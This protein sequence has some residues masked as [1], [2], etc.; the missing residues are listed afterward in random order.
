M[1]FFYKLKHCINNVDQ[2]RLSSYSS[3]VKRYDWSEM[4]AEYDAQFLSVAN[5]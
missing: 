4:I 3:L 1:I 2:I 5:K